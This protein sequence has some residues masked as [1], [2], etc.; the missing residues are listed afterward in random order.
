M[1]N[2]TSQFQVYPV[3]SIMDM[4]ECIRVPCF[5]KIAMSN[6]FVDSSIRTGRKN[7][8]DSTSTSSTVLDCKLSSFQ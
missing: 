3:K 7:S 4:A 6:E 8:Y 1:Q 2:V 5:S